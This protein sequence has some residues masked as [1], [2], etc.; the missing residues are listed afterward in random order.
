[1][2]APSPAYAQWDGGPGQRPHQA[3]PN[4]NGLQIGGKPFAKQ[5]VV[6][7]I[8]SALVATNETTSSLSYADLATTGPSVT[9]V[10]GT[11]AVVWLSATVYR[12][13]GAGNTAQLSVAVSGATTQAAADA[14]AASFSATLAGYVSSMSRSALLTGLTPGVNTFT[15]KYKVDGGTFSLYNR[16]ITVFAP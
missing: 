11:T 16:Q 1:M 2:S 15:L 9:L 13:S 4:V 12:P 8:Q 10:T 14:N 6:T 7:A 5:G 3:A